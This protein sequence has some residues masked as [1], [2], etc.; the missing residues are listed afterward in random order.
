MKQVSM[1]VVGV[2]RR[3]GI[4]KNGGRPY[5]MCQVIAA[6]P[7]EARKDSL[8]EVTGTGYITE[9][10]DAEPALVDQV[11]GVSFPTMAEV[12]IDVTERNG[13]FYPRIV[14]IE[15]DKRSQSSTS[16]AKAAS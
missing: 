15:A 11:Q 4:S 12:S 7:V 2:Q 13:R 14:G 1:L 3:Q 8:S 9:E 6:K 5:D 10:M 16:G